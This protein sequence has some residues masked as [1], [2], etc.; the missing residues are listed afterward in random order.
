[1]KVG[2]VGVGLLGGS[3]GY[4]LKEKKWAREVVGIGRNEEKLKKAI[5]LKT[6]DSYELEINKKVSELDILIL[7]VPV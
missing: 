3:L 6:I 5:E 7:A 2:I 4:I 1:M